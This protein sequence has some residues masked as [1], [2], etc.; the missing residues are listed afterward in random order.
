M[1]KRITTAVISAVLLLSVSCS[2]LN[3]TNVAVKMASNPQSELDRRFTITR[4][5]Y[6]G[7]SELDIAY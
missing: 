6:V 5:E 3:I 2:A 7:Y 1:F 4:D